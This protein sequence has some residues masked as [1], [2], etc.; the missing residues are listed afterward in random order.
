MSKNSTI[1]A[2]VAALVA[3]PVVASAQADV[4]PKMR[5]E[6]RFKAADQDGNGTLSK[7][8]VSASM[9][10]LADQFDALDVN[11]DGQLSQVELRAARGGRERRN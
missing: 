6:E 8:E 11:K 3:I 7:E 5:A 2:L 1:A 9:P 4:E 10:R